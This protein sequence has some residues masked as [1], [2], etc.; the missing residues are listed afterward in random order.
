VIAVSTSSEALRAFHR[1]LK[2]FCDRPEGRALVYSSGEWASNPALDEEIAKASWEEVVLPEE[3]VA[4]IRA[5]TETFFSHREAYTSLGFAW[6][7]GVLLV[8]PP[9]SRRPP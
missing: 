4:E 9:G 5:A 3:Q 7:R 6:R 1:E 8:G 2:E